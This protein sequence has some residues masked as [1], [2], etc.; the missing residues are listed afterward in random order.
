MQAIEVNHEFVTEDQDKRA[1]YQAEGWE[2]LCE[3]KYP[4]A[5][6][7][8]RILLGDGTVLTGFTAQLN[9]LGLGPEGEPFET[10]FV[11]TENGFRQIIAL[12]PRYVVRWVK[13]TL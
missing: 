10:V 7:E 1:D 9:Y 8:L 12:D 6:I 5:G 13:P 11:T 4:P 2:Y 3:D